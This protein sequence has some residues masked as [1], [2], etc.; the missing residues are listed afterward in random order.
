MI[1]TKT[2]KKICS[3]W[4]GGQWSALYQ[5]A[6]S[7]HF[8]CENSILYL[9]EIMQDLQ[10]EFFAPCPRTLQAN[11]IKELNNLKQYFESEIKRATFLEIEYKK[12]PIYGYLY[13][14]AVTGNQ[15]INE[16][17]T[18]RLQN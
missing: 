9:W 15:G 2:A 18:I 7:S 12:H 8:V 14:D 11:E 6:S 10:N 16:L 5:F 17:K 13:P 4:H 3:S 1:T